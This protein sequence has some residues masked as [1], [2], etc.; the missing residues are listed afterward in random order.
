MS[1]K[2]IFLDVQ[3]YKLSSVAEEATNYGDENIY[4]VQ[5][6]PMLMHNEDDNIIVIPVQQ[7]FDKFVLGI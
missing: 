6:G 5:H 3:K 7:T 4:R 2:D 1:G